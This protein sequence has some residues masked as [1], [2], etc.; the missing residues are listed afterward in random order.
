MRK[1]A[2]A[3]VLLLAGCAS[4]GTAEDFTWSIEAPKTADKGAEFTFVVRALSAAGQMVD[5]V[6]I[7]YQTVWPGGSPNPL[8]HRG[9]TGEPVKVHAR[10]LPG[11][12][13]ILVL[14][15]NREGM[16]VKVAETTFEVK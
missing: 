5:G 10:V 3:V 7:R 14:S 8:R 6:K 15:E 12:A 11:P 2:S 13:T 9:R 4:P 1:F 16:E